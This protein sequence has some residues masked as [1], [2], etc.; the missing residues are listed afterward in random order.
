MGGVRDVAFESTS[1]GPDSPIGYVFASPLVPVQRPVTAYAAAS[2]PPGARHPR[3]RR[4]P[5]AP[6]PHRFQIRPE[7]DRDLDAARRSVRE[8][9]RRLP[10]FR[11]CD[12]RR[13]CAASACRPPMSAA[14]CAP[15]RRRASRGCRAPTRPTPGSRC[16]A[17]R[18][19]GWIGFDPTN[20][21]LVENDHIV[22]AVGRDYSDVSPVDGI[23]VGSRKQKLA[24][25]VDV[26]LVDD[27]SPH[28]EP[29]NVHDVIILGAG[30]AGLMCAVVAGQ[31][32][33]RC[34][35]WSRRGSRARRS[36]SPAAGA[37]ISPTCTRRPRISCRTIRASAIRR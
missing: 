26:L 31:R 35:C 4:R 17:A 28:P 25:A 14:I 32:G 30:A 11:P 12:D 1:L 19:S 15:S 37:A 10:G 8:A 7:G 6:D 18:R 33:R 21:I 36:A 5:D 9:P 16:G 2:F 20:D 29:P 22:L 3:R 34:W 24:V 27:A 13:A 23:I